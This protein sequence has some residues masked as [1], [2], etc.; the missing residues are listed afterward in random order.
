MCEGTVIE[1][2]NNGKFFFVW[3][4]PPALLLLT[5]ISVPLFLTKYYQLFLSIVCNSR[6]CEKVPC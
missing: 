3:V 6:G 5:F 4:P 1:R 2:Q